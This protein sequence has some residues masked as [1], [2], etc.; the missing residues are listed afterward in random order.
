MPLPRPFR[1]AHIA[2]AVM[3]LVAGI[4]ANAVY[5]QDQ[6]DASDAPRAKEDGVRI[7]T[8]VITGRGD[9][10][11][12][13]QILNEDAV[14]GRSTVT[15]AA[16]EKDRATGNAFQS[17]ALLPGVNTYS[18]DATGLFGGGITVRGF[19]GDQLGLTINGV[20]VNDSGSYTVFPQEYVDQENLCSQ[21][22]AQGNPDIESPHVGATGG[23][24]N[25]VSCDPEDKQRVRFTQTFGGL[26]LSRSFVRVDSGRFAD[27]KAKVFASV[28]HTEADKWKGEGGAKRDH[29]DAAFS[30][31]PTPD[32][33]IVGSVLYNRAVNNNF[34]AISNAQ[35]NANGYFY[36][37]ASAFT[38]GHLS[39]V[40]GTAQKETGPSPQYY[41]LATNPFEN[42]ILSVSAS[43]KLAE[44]T[45]LKVQPYY[46]YG[47]GT[48]GTQQKTLSETGLLNTSTGKVGAAVDLNGDG[49]T[50][51]TV[52]IANSSVTRTQRPGIIAELSHALGAHQLKFG[53]WYERAQHRQTGPAVAVN[54]D[55]SSADVWLRSGLILRPDGTPY[56]SRDWL[57]VSPAYQA[58][59]ADTI[60]VLDNKGVVQLGV[61]TPHVT[62]QFTNHASE[63]GGNS[64]ISYRYEKSFSDVLPQAGLR[65]NVTKEQQVFANIGKNFR[66]PPNFALAPTNN[67]ITFANGVPT[68]AGSVQAET[69]VATDVGYR[70]QSNAV[71]LSA[72]MFYVD[73]KNRQSNAYDPVLDKSIYTNAGATRKQGLEFE[74]GSPV[75][76]GFT[77]Y[78]SLTLQKETIQD[79][80]VVSKALTLK[81]SGKQF[82]LT[83]N[84]MVGTSLQYASGPYYVRAK[85]KYTGKQYATLMND[86]Q[87]PAYVTGD[88]DAG[89][90]FAD[91]G[92]LKSP[93]LRA[94]LSNIGNARYRNPSSGSS[95]TNVT[96]AGRTG[97]VVTYYLGAPRLFSVSFSADF[98]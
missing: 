84:T 40:N 71:T 57:T 13:G 28:S 3:V 75:W 10:L 12:A 7:G 51:D 80:L 47:Y 43:L 96:Q 53:L 20:P 79:D 30:F 54:A 19:G 41:Q 70:F 81:T 44:A 93:L 21:S 69:S 98:Q 1:A 94:N 46:W 33:S 59:V 48:G 87:A 27:G 16:T 31:D 18:H 14:K 35:L 76:N 65:Y 6:A 8:I 29:V 62:R 72:T 83:P 88:L 22:V 74:A 82:T 86:E 63:A 9:R 95:L 66:A 91:I 64:L 36:D 24:I 38:P 90:K 58:Y 78:A 2:R 26:K 97:D 60:S 77:A 11:G 89:Y 5:A 15:R 42:A 67:N 45:F 56:E 25:I 73:F 85:V 37:Y 34:L 61:R 23:S 49:D 4:A 55:G 39:A 50:L 68:L 17:L 32:A 92:M 52:V